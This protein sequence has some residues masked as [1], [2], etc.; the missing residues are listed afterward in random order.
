MTL[1]ASIFVLATLAVCPAQAPETAEK[2]KEGG[3]PAFV[4]PAGRTELSELIERCRAYLQWNILVKE[5]ELQ[6]APADVAVELQQPVR[7]DADGCVDMFSSLLWMNGFALTPVDEARG[8]YEII[9]RNGPRA[10][11]VAARAVHRTVEQVMARPDSFLCVTTVVPLEHINATIATNALRPFFA[12]RSG[13]GGTGLTLGNV[14]HNASL[15]LSGP[16]NAVASAI[17]LLRLADVAP[18]EPAP[19]LAEQVAALAKQVEALTA[20]LAAL[21]KKLEG[22]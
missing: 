3:K 14:G 10:R 18:K 11:E 19:G 6:M 1:R 21:E 9:A 13:P 8:V 17:G 7:T 4:F 20:R 16:Q 12:S 5:Q 15:V 22:R 2:P